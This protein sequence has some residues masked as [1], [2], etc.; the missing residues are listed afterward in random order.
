MKPR[1]I[2]IL[3]GVALVAASGMAQAQFGNF[4]RSITGAFS[5]NNQPQQGSTATIGIRGIDDGGAVVNAPAS[6][7]NALIDG[8]VATKPEA[9]YLAK[10]KGLAARDVRVKGAA[11]AQSASTNN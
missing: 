1:L 2:H 8:W 10:E 3:T 6:P 9:E 4:L 5:G 7:D 11:T